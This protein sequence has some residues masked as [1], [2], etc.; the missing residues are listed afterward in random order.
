MGI[1]IDA[2]DPEHDKLFKSAVVLLPLGQLPCSC[3]LAP[4]VSPWF[5]RTSIAERKVGTS[6][7]RGRQL[8]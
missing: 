3:L 5:R 8:A 6:L 7:R 1:E 4:N 2:E